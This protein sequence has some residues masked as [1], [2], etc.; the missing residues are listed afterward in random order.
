MCARRA[1]G[2]GELIDSVFSRYGV[3]VFRSAMEDILEKPVLA[4]VT[5]ALAASRCLQDPPSPRDGSTQS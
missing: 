3:P 2:Y 1:D 5:S 4:L